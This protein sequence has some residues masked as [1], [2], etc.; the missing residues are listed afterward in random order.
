VVS[1]G[2]T[3][4][5]PGWWTATR[6]ALGLTQPSIHVVR[7]NHPWIKW[8]KREAGHLHASSDLVNAFRCTSMVP[9]RIHDIVLNEVKRLVYIYLTNRF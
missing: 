8:P 3:P 4:F 9:I 6:P 5:I 1:R 2:L 7:G